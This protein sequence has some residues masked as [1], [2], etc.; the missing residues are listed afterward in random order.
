MD[1]TKLRA[2]YNTKACQVQ[3]YQIN[4]SGL[5]DKIREIEAIKKDIKV[6]K[7]DAK[8]LKEKIQNELNKDHEYWKGDLFRTNKNK[9]KD[10][11]IE[12][13]FN[14]YI[15]KIDDNLDKLNTKQMQLE[16]EIHS[17]EGL[18]GSLK[19]GMNWLSTQID[20]LFN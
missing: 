15:N 16:N 3:E 9:M 6:L 4:I 12:S 18:I 1:A 2:D 8:D 17:T 13:G 19:S 11:L 20:N 10:S 7:K 5:E 14:T